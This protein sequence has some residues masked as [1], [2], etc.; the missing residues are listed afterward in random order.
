MKICMVLIPQL[1]V[2]D[3]LLFTWRGGGGTKRG[4]GRVSKV[5]PVQKA[6]REG[7][8]SF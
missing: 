8:G 5:L 7:G 1:V 6:R 4:G 2:R 3:R